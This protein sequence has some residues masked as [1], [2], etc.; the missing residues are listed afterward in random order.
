MAGLFGR[1]GPAIDAD[2][3]RFFTKLVAERGF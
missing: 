1:N 2:C 3:R